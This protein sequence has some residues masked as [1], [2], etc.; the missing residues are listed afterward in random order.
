[1]WRFLQIDENSDVC[2]RCGVKMA[3]YFCF[4]CKSFRGVHKNPYH[5]DLCGICRPD[6][7]K[8]Y[9]CEGCNVCL[10]KR[11]KN[12]HKCL[13]I[14]DHHVQCCICLEDVFRSCHVWKC[15]HKMHRKCAVDYILR[16]GR[17]TCPICRQPLKRFSH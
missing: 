10:K 15:G 2:G 12:N 7:D 17:K 5:C 16:G 11:L 13:P 14:S 6:K 3:E 1:M 9:H 4:T 8:M